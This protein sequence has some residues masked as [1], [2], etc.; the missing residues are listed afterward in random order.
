MLAAHLLY[1]RRHCLHTFATHSFGDFFSLVRHPFALSR[2]IVYIGSGVR[3]QCVKL[4]LSD[5]GATTDLYLL[6]LFGLTAQVH[7]LL[8]LYSFPL[9]H[10]RLAMKKKGSKSSSL[11]KPGYGEPYPC[12]L[13]LPPVL[14][15]GL[16]YCACISYSDWKR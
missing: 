5:I 4:L 10:L 1:P 2:S 3:P 16:L 14:D 9:N 6:R 12:E 15:P 11:S 7:T 13:S 8:D